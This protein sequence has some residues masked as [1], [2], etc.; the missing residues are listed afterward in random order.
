MLQ[1]ATPPPTVLGNII[2]A[3]RG[4]KPTLT[5]SMSNFKVNKAK[6]SAKQQRSDL[7]IVFLVQCSQGSIEQTGYQKTRAT[8][9]FC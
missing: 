2:L 5:Y 7:V 9:L 8:V 6:R 4:F 3:N 1:G